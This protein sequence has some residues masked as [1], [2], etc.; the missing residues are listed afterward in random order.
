MEKEAAR[1][2]LGKGRRAAAGGDEGAGGGPS[3]AQGRRWCQRARR[4]RA[5]LENAELKEAL[6]E[7]M[8]AAEERRRS[9]EEEQKE[10][11]NDK[12]EKGAASSSYGDAARGRGEGQKASRPSTRRTSGGPQ[13]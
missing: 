6:D 2:P 7:K 12:A 1:E 11:L 8:S 9:L 10:K 4:R 3:R 13:V 5:S